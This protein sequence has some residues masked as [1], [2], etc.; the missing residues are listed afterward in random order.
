MTKV[1]Y[2]IIKAEAKLPT[3]DI[4]PVLFFNTIL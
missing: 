2:Y 3:F 4:K 1:Q